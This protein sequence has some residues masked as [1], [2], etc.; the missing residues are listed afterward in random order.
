MSAPVAPEPFLVTKESEAEMAAISSNLRALP[1]NERSKTLFE[2]LKKGIAM[3]VTKATSPTVPVS[4]A[5]IGLLFTIVVQAGVGIW[6]ASSMSKEVEFNKQEIQSL[7]ST[8]E[9]R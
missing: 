8:V 5:V 1:Q 4:P 9:T 3:T 2:E 7:K 6:W